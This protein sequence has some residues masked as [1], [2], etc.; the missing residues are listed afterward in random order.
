MLWRGTFLLSIGQLFALLSAY[1]IHV[2]LARELG[3]TGYGTFGVVY[4]ILMI[5]ELLVLAGIPNAIQRF[6]GENPEQSYSLHKLLFRW[7]LVYALAVFAI[8]YFLTP[9]IAS[10]FNDEK[11]SFLLRLAIFDIVIFGLYWYYNG[12]PIGQRRFGRQTIIASTY[13]IS[14]FI[15]IVVMILLGFGVAGA[16]VGNILGSL[17]GM[18]IG[19]VLLEIKSKETE[20]SKSKLRQFIVPNII[21]WIGLNLIFYVDLWFVKYYLPGQT[22]GYYNAASTLGR[23]PYFFSL[24][25]TGAILPTL[26]YAIA[27]KDLEETRRIIQQSLRLMWLVLLPLSV[28]VLSASQQLIVLFFGEAYLAA[29]EIFKILFI[30]SCCLSLFAVMNTIVIAKSGMIGCGILVLLLTFADLGLN[31]IL[32]PR[33]QANGAAAATM[34]TFITGLVFSSVYVVYQF[35]IFAKIMSLIRIAGVTLVIFF[36]TIFF[37]ATGLSELML[38]FFI[39]GAVYLIMLRAIG[40]ISNTEMNKVKVA[41]ASGFRRVM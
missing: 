24:A 4:S 9:F 11:I 39:L 18:L 6:I 38:K 35:K 40:E 37:K 15:F 13:S 2:F 25:L 33:F 23:I 27:Q 12:F 34:I 29:T 19:F 41:F 10:L 1:G 3:P 36:A 17:T 14:K 26:S 31:A 30:A 7:Q 28:F 22:V 8:I 5:V 32:V 20:V 16:F 21:Y